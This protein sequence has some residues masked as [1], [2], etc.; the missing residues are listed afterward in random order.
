MRLN[1]LLWLIN[2][3][4]G[5][6]DLFF[7]NWREGGGLGVAQGRAHLLLQNHVLQD[8]LVVHTL[9]HF[10]RSR[11]IVAELWLIWSLIAQ[12]SLSNEVL[13]IKVDWV[14]IHLVDFLVGSHIFC[15]GIDL[16]SSDWLSLHSWGKAGIEWL[17][18]SLISYFA[19][20]WSSCCQLNSC[21]KVDLI[22][23]NFS[24]N[25]LNGL[26]FFYVVHFFNYKSWFVAE[27]S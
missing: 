21:E 4:D 25:V 22:T 15:R 9:F 16:W 14:I 5:L 8:L 20:H 13:W 26:V 6:L 17:V 1:L 18:W 10:Q 2:S 24:L 11:G 27:I 12:N 3:L 19:A 7:E 23:D